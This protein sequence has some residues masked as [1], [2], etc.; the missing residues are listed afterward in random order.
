MLFSI[1][2]IEGWDLSYDKAC[3]FVVR[4]SS[5]SHAR[6]LASEQAGDEGA[7]T[8]LDASK[9][10]CQAIDPNGPPGVLCRDFVSA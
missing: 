9:T 10:L 5:G 3:S 6:Q 1:K 4:A 7:E 8:W 2:P